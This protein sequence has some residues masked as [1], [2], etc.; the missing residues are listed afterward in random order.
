MTSRKKLRELLE[1]DRQKSAEV[2]AARITDIAEA[3]A[4]LG[5]QQGDPLAGVK[6][7]VAARND[8]RMLT[9]NPL[10]VPLLHEVQ[11][12]LDEIARLFRRELIRRLLLEK[13]EEQNA[14]ECL[15]TLSAQVDS[16]EWENWRQDWMEVEDQV[17]EKLAAERTAPL[18]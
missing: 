11:F 15:R 12:G 6:A 7:L 9:Q 18:M 3:R 2:H 14:A 5:R 17:C 4:R 1:Q 10:L 13:I 16:G 8:L